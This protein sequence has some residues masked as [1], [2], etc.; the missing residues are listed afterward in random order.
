MITLEPIKFFARPKLRLSLA[1]SY[2]VDVG[3]YVPPSSPPI[4]IS[5][6]FILII[7]L[8]IVSIADFGIWHVSK[9]M[10]IGLIKLSIHTMSNAAW[11]IVRE[12]IWAIKTTAIGMYDSKNE[13]DTT[14]VTLNIRL[15][16]FEKIEALW[17]LKHLILN[18]TMI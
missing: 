4:F 1:N 10:V 5:D 9:T 2:Y 16:C 17:I 18:T 15:F 13:V 12:L 6:C 8:S 7:F 11:K 14:I 3:L